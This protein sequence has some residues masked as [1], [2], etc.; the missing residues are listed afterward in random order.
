[1]FNDN[2]LTKG[3][4]DMQ[5]RKFTENGASASSGT[6]GGALLDLFAMAG[7]L[8]DRTD[9]TARLYGRA[10]IEDPL[11][12]AKLAFYTRDVRG[13]LGERKTART[14]FRVL[15]EQKPEILKKNL[16]LIAEYGRYDDLICLLDTNVREEVLALLHSR[17][18]EDI[19]SMGQGG[20]VSLCAKW[21]PSVNAS[22][23]QTRRRAREI[24]KSFGMSE[25]EYRKILSALRAYMN[26]TEVRLSAN[27]YEQIRYDTVPSYAMKQYS[28][29][30]RR[31]D[32][33]RFREYLMRVQKGEAA[34]HSDTLFPYDLAAE[35]VG[36]ESWFDVW[37]NG[38]QVRPEDPAVEA[39][40]KALPD[41]LEQPENCLIM[42]DLSASMYGQPI[43][44][45]VSLG[46]YF[47][48]RNKGAFRDTVL[49]FAGV[50]RLIRLEGESLHD[51]MQYIFS[52]EA[53]YNTDLEAAFD[54]V[55]QTAV[56]K[57]LPQEEIPDH[58]IVISDGEIDALRTQTNWHFTDEM[59]ARFE[60]CG[61]RMPS[62]VLWNADARHDTF[63]ASA[64]APDVQL[65]SGRASSVFKTL[66][67]SLHMTPY[68]YMIHVLNDS[69]YEAI[70]I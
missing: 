3:M 57:H 12:A 5:N 52:T 62:L 66:I 15:A 67:G 29:A 33:R 11:L 37:N 45:S 23:V 60:A 61:Y 55:L 26:V 70:T 46:I 49:L 68:E 32:G 35:Y 36:L 7:S 24:A 1:M 38:I 21:M 10:L 14:M 48:E 44:T 42:V 25:K 43:L 39:Q 18:E 13:G 34:I 59:R 19:R 30:F 53:G 56:E 27:D 40:W 50:P 47:A 16:P 22:S 41:Y 63:H 9:H 51:K 6:G 28:D 20:P 58:I 17:L 54:L 64:D 4:M 31:H 2:S 8:R 65:C 69:R